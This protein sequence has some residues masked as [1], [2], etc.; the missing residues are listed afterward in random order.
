MKIGAYATKW[1][2]IFTGTAL[3]WMILEKALGWHD[4]HIDRHA[5]LTN[6]F[7]IVAIAIFVFALLD[8]RESLGGVMTW[9]EGFLAGL[10]ISVV[11][12]VLSPLS[13]WLTHTLISPDYFPNIIAY[14]VDNGQMTQQQAVSYFTLSNYMLQSAIGA[15]VM[16]AATAAVAAIFIKRNPPAG[17]AGAA[18]ASSDQN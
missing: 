7:A 11:V 9:K 12:A 5:D 10:A 3:V 1:G 18:E 13:Q 6:L 4:T 17:N 16:G 15:L 2:L 14:S 8:R